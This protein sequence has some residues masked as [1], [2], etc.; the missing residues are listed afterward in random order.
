MNILRRAQAIPD[1]SGRVVGVRPEG[2]AWRFIH[3]DA[4]RLRSGQTLRGDSGPNE[5]ALI[6]LGGRC[7]VHAGSERFPGVGTR[8]SLWQRVSPPVLLLP[9]RTPFEI[10]PE[11]SLHLAIAGAEATRGYPIRLIGAE[12]IVAERRGEGQ[13]ERYIHHLLPPSSPAERLILVEVYTPGGNWSSFPPHKHD[14]EDPPRESYLEEIY[15]FGVNPP[16]GFAVQRV[17]TPDRTLDQTVATQD[18]DLVLVPRGYHVV[19]ATPGHECYY[20]NVMAG[21]SR[22]WNFTLDPDYAT[23][24]NWQKPAVAQSEAR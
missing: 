4:Y 11:T 2:E 7:S 17:Y 22:A 1:H 10:Q 8:D 18:G 3:F 15:Y 24:L 9:P 20:L 5:T 23:L 12:E 6:V 16:S 19:A 13:T 14:T 21:L